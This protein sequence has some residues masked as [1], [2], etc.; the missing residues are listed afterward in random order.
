MFPITAIL[1]LAA[2]YIFFDILS[3]TTLKYSRTKSLIK[4]ILTYWIV[5]H[6]ILFFIFHLFILG[7]LHSYRYSSNTAF[8]N[9]TIE[10]NRL[11]QNSKGVYMYSSKTIA[12]LPLLE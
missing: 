6:V 11:L 2:L 5:F 1:I 9:S 10:Y 7:F 3:G 8:I 12:N 4:T